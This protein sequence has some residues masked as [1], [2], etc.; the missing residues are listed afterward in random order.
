[1]LTAD[2]KQSTCSADEKC[3]HFSK[4]KGKGSVYCIA[5][6]VTSRSSEMG[7]P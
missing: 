4:G 7:F 3:L 2:D 6:N 5:V 1:V